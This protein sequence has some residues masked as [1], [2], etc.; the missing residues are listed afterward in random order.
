MKIK[1]I[2]LFSVFSF[3]LITFITLT[4]S[5]VY[6]ASSNYHL[7]T[8]F[9]FSSDMNIEKG[10]E[11]I[12]PYILYDSSY[13]AY[14]YDYEFNVTNVSGNSYKFTGH[15][16]DGSYFSI[17]STIKIIDDASG[18]YVESELTR[19]E[20]RQSIYVTNLKSGKTTS[21]C[22][23][24]CW[25]NRWVNIKE[26]T[27]SIQT[28]SSPNGAIYNNLTTFT[29]GANEDYV[30]HYY[31]IYN[32]DNYQESTNPADD[33][34][35]LP[36]GDEDNNS[37]ENTSS[38]NNEDK[39]NNQNNDSQQTQQKDPVLIILIVIGGIILLVLGY[40]LYKVIRMVLSWLDE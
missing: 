5:N 15:Y 4:S 12:K 27:Y 31:A 14:L 23:L 26:P 3:L 25:R 21:D 32:P 35:S 9:T 28:G 20:Y 13:K 6:A 22:L 29:S 24:E 10:F 11:Y 2:K 16:P 7:A 39:T 34:I 37:Q 1:L 19:G 8:S 30:L 17:T 40:M 38:S 33:I 18:T 36:S